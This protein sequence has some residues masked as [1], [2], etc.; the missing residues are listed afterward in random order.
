MHRKLNC[1]LLVDDD[2]TNNFITE[3]ILRKMDICKTVKTSCNGEEALLYLTRY[4]SP[5]NNNF[6]ELIL[7]DNH[8]PEM[9]GAEFMETLHKIELNLCQKMKVVVLTS[10]TD[11]KDESK[12]REMGVDAYISKP[13]TEEKIKEVLAG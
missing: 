4:G 3:K 12:M 8:M 5:D 7:L 11:P 9:N 1:V 6:P 2:K 13:L 10:S